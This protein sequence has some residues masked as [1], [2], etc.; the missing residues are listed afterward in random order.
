[1]TTK[2][3]IEELLYQNADDFKIAKVLKED[4]NCY[5]KTLD[6]SFATSGGKDFLFK[7]TRKIDSIL[8]LIYKIA[9]RGMFKEYMPLK[10]SLPL[11][12]TAL[13]S[14]G[15]EQLCVYSDIDLLIVYQDIAGYNIKEMIEKILYLIW[16]SGL[17]LGHRVHHID[18]LLDVSRTDITIKTALLESRFLDGSRFLWTETQNKL[19]DIRHDQ[20]K[21]YIEEKLKERERMHQKFPL[22]M[23][24]NLKEGEGGFRDANLVYWIGKIKYNIN[25]IADL[26]EHIIGDIDYKEFRISLEFLFRVRSAL[27]LVAGKKEDK[28]RL[29]LIPEVAGFLGYL[30]SRSE[31]MKF[32]KKVLTSLR[33]VQLYSSIWIDTLSC[34]Y[35]IK[36]EESKPNILLAVESKEA[37]TLQ[38]IIKRLNSEAN[39]EYEASPSLLHQLVQAEKPT[40]IT[41]NYYPQ[42]RAIFQQKYSYSVLMTLSRAHL[43]GY[44]IPVIANVVNLPQ[45]DGYHRFSVHA[46]LLECMYALEH[47]ENEFI[48]ELYDDLTTKERELL[49]IVTFLHDA[50]KGRKRDHSR[51]GA[52][53]FRLYAGQLKLEKEMTDIG[54]TL[55]LY[56]T[57]MSDTAQREDLYNEKTIFKFAAHFKNKKMLDMIY[58]LTYADMCGVDNNIYTTFRARLLHTLY[59]Q[60][61]QTLEHGEMLSETAKRIKKEESLKRSEKFLSLAKSK[62]KKI[63]SI[64]SNLMFMRYRPEQIIAIANDAST[65]TNYTY[66]IHSENF[67]TIELIREGTVNL[68][69][70]LAKLSR[71]NLVNMD[72]CKLFDDLKYFKIDFAETI[73]EHEKPL[74][75][76]Y[77]AQAFEADKT[78]TMPTPYIKQKDIMIECEHSKDY[79]KMSLKTE[80]QKGL[81]AYLITRFDTLGI[82]IVSAK[83]HTQRNR[84][85][86]LFLIEKNG[87]FCMNKDKIIESMGV[88]E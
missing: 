78:F 12:M 3:K 29:D 10:N 36:I 60:S 32:A 73:D 2:D 27:H 5:F 57:L 23:E 26:P 43:L 81:L 28:L 48:K 34:E 55:I 85:Q 25:R 13:G 49:K 53:L 75:E 7:H 63:L 74:I 14:Y 80:N 68:G 46:H 33:V 30:A 22:G 1:M 41:E 87:N 51:V 86:D 42:I 17:K 35:G 61:L 72:I 21:L 84:V 11:T 59:T 18:E 47:I 31:H 37:K 79:A 67:L 6:E 64:P 9:L 82:D 38:S 62:Q 76:A 65:M 54:I 69:Y 4:I 58:I 8:K 71:L 56:H 45:F 50:G 70:L 88:E 77:I 15:R 24:P 40:K 83:I 20:P 66:S 16:D 19:D 39:K 44:S 52:T